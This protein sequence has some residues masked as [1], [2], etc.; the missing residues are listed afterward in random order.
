MSLTS[1]TLRLNGAQSLQWA[2]VIEDKGVGG[3]MHLVRH[4]LAK[5]ERKAADLLQSCL[6]DVARELD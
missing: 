4:S 5:E 3:A 6:L 2:V 1:I